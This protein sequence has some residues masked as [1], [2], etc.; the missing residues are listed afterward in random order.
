MTKPY[1]KCVGV[2]V[3][4][5]KKV[6]LCERKD[7][8]GQWQFPQGGIEQGEDFIVAATRELNEETSISSVVAVDTIDSP[9][10]YDFPENI[11]NNGK[12]KFNGQ[13]TQWV[14]FRFEGDDGEI[15]LQTKEPEFRNWRWEDIDEAPKK[16]VEFKRDV[17]Q[18]VVKKFKPWV[19]EK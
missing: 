2:V 3:F 19:E 4:K 12:W 18:Q 16:I 10:R 13:D 9:I 1:R 14:L 11:K 7:I 17:Y 8:A 15:N 5:N 6:L